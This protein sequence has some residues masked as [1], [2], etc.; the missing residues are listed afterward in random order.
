MKII[1][2]STPDLVPDAARTA[3]FLNVFVRQPSSPRRR[4]I[5]GR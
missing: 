3:L 2:Q 1:R 5:R 4:T